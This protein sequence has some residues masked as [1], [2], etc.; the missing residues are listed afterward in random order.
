VQTRGQYILH[1][2][3]VNLSMQALLRTQK[4]TSFLNNTTLIPD[5]SAVCYLLRKSLAKHVQLYVLC[6]RTPVIFMKKVKQQPEATHADPPHLYLYQALRPAS[7]GRLSPMVGYFWWRLRCVE[8]SAKRYLVSPVI[9]AT[10][11][12]RQRWGSLAISGETPY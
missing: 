9:L 6:R 5:W 12:W 1:G 11:H 8:M 2:H 4:Q 10:H 7:V 3:R